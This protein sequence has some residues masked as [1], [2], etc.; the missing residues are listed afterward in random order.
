MLDLPTKQS[1]LWGT[2]GCWAGGWL[3]ACQVREPHNAG[4][5]MVITPTSW[6]AGVETLECFEA[7]NVICATVWGESGSITFVES[8]RQVLTSVMCENV[9]LYRKAFI[10]YSYLLLFLSL[11][12]ALRSISQWPLISLRPMVRTV[13]FSVLIGFVLCAVD[14]QIRIRFC[15]NLWFVSLF[16]L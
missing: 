5:E 7:G 10:W 11:S 3:S 14:Q 15:L 13:F 1:W 16:K 6:T 12:L 4:L 2:S 8:H 9:G